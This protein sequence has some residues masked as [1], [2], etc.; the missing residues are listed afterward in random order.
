MPSRKHGRLGAGAVWDDTTDV[1]IDKRLKPIEDS[2]NF[3][4]KELKHTGTVPVEKQK[5]DFEKAKATAM[6]LPKSCPYPLKACDIDQQAKLGLSCPPL[7]VAPNPLMV[8]SSGNLCF[9]VAEM[10]KVSSKTNGSIDQLI[11]ERSQELV[12]FMDNKRFL[13]IITRTAL[14]D[15]GIKQ[16]TLQVVSEFL[17]NDWFEA[18][19]KVGVAVL[20]LDAQTFNAKIRHTKS[21][22][23][24]EYLTNKHV[25]KGNRGIPVHSNI[26]AQVTF[27]GNPTKDPAT[28][29]WSWSAT[30]S[31]VKYDFTNPVA[32]PQNL[33]NFTSDLNTFGAAVL[34]P[35]LTINQ[36]TP[37]VQLLGLVSESAFRMALLWAHVYDR[38]MDRQ[39]PQRKS[40]IPSRVFSDR[41]QFLNDLQGLVKDAFSRTVKPGVPAAAAAVTRGSVAHPDDT[42]ILAPT[43]VTF[44][45]EKDISIKFLGGENV[46]IRFADG[47]GEPFSFKFADVWGGG[48]TMGHMQFLADNYIW[49]AENFTLEVYQETVAYIKEVLQHMADPSKPKPA[50]KAKSDQAKLFNPT[51]VVPA[52]IKRELLVPCGGER[53]NPAVAAAIRAGIV[54]ARTAGAAAGTTAAANGFFIDST[55]GN[56]EPTQVVNFPAVAPMK[57]NVDA[58]V[59][60]FDGARAAFEATLPVAVRARATALYIDAYWSA[61]ASKVPKFSGAA[62]TFAN[63]IAN[64][65]GVAEDDGGQ[66]Y[67]E[68]YAAAA[69][70]DAAALSVVRDIDAALG[71]AAVAA[72]PAVASEIASRIP[73][74]INFARAVNVI[75]KPAD[76]DLSTQVTTA[77][78]DNFVAGVMARQAA[79]AAAAVG[80]AA[81][82][83]G[84]AA[85]AAPAPFARANGPALFGG[86]AVTLQWDAAVDCIS[87][88]PSDVFRMFKVVASS[89]FTA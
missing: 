10:K 70:A 2:L 48:S 45:V 57:A 89:T 11:E 39:L 86:A 30:L 15:S 22:Q 37:E 43:D 53:I 20:P 85:A 66:F 51:S 79:V 14:K 32:V 74:A 59:A 60:G 68:L 44:E 24:I 82:A 88:S 40:S 52:L 55:S 8:D 34:A 5:R 83:G 81:A 25:V 23:I 69:A 38:Q 47:A 84:G 65:E 49:A 9:P 26:R 62:I 50:W 18:Q 56:D 12:K 72:V 1:A 21:G 16:P 64:I 4:L 77:Y 80:G 67:E 36:D 78:T 42:L 27:T 35:P 46:R 7:E 33:Q 58:A 17:L 28:N 71:A 31:V 6:V 13:D 61:F 76:A 75:S 73:A 87:I 54:A 63:A 19:A 29:K 3:L 41:I